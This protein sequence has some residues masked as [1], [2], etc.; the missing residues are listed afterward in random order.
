MLRMD[1]FSKIESKTISEY[2]S[3]DAEEMDVINVVNAESKV[4]KED[5][6]NDDIEDS[7]EQELLCNPV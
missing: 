5:A 1:V 2:Q 6:G 7:A 3:N 4:E